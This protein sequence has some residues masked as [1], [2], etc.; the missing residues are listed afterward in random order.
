MGHQPQKSEAE[1][2]LFSSP[3]SPSPSPSSRK[4]LPDIVAQSERDE[5]G[6]SSGRRD[7]GQ[8]KLCVRG[9]W[10]PSED[11]K[12][13]DLVARYGP[14]NWNFIADKLNGRSGKSCRL[15]WFNQLDPK[16]NKTAFSEEEEE[17]LVA[18]H[19]IYGNKWALMARLF[20]GRTDNAVKNQWHVLMARKEREQGSGCRRRKAL[21]Q[22]TE[23]SS[24]HNNA[25]SGESSITS[26]RDESSSTCTGSRAMPCFLKDFG[27]AQQQQP[28]QLC[29]GVFH[30]LLLLSRCQL[31]PYASG[32]SVFLFASPVQEADT[33]SGMKL[34]KDQQSTIAAMASCQVKLMVIERR[35]A[36]PSSISWVLEFSFSSRNEFNKSASCTESL[37]RIKRVKS[38]NKHKKNEKNKKKK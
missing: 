29:F 2:R 4:G 24:G 25:W 6:M 14:Q 26:S 37:K 12:L 8:A 7:H 13:M 1:M 16:I 23:V 31:S 36:F 11:A 34:L 22:R 18:S 20:P 27:M 30:S 28:L 21:P 3:P 5:R 33:V 35:S 9:H 10:K 19:R 32:A 38:G 17:K 15:R